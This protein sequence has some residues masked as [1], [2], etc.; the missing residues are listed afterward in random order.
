MSLSEGAIKGWDKR[1]EFYYQIIKSLSNHY[2]FN[3]DS[4]F[5]SLNKKVQNII[6]N[7]TGEEEIK[8]NYYNNSGKKV[9]KLQVF[10]GVLNNFERRYN[11]TESS[12]VRDEL[13][14]YLSKQICAECNGTRL[15]EHARN[16]LIN[17]LNIADISVMPIEE[18]LVFFGKLTLDGKRKKI[19]DRLVEEISSRLGFLN[20]VGLN[21]L[22]LDRSAETLSG[23]RRIK[24]LGLQVKLELA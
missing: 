1:N 14:K 17:N 19:A 23:G 8:F 13:N 2:K 22:S 4:S 21:Y 5:S 20:N 6:L 7:G 16:V 10:E 18:C 11:N 12:F 9:S 15:S 3:I 24:E